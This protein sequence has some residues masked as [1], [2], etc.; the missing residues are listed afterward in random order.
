MCFCTQH[1]RGDQSL[2]FKYNNIQHLRERLLQEDS[3][4]QLCK[5]VLTK[6]NV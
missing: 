6:N 4:T 2:G 3:L 1:R 5:C